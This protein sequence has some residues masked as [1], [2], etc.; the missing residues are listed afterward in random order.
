MFSLT[1]APFY[2]DRIGLTATVKE[3]MALDPI[4]RYHIGEPFYSGPDPRLDSENLLLSDARQ[5]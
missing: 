3:K 1:A 4:Y 2:G 5:D